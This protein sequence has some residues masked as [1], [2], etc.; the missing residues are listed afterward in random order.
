MPA[1]WLALI[2]AGQ[3]LLAHLSFGVFTAFED[4]GLYLFM[5]HRM[6]DHLLHGT[7]LR[8]YPGAF[9]SGAPGIYPVLA[10]LADDAGGLSAARSLSLIFVMVATVGVYGLTRT[11]FDR[12]AGLL[13]AATFATCGSVIYQSQWAT[14]D[15]MTMML[16]VLGAWLAL[17]GT[18]RNG[19]LWAAG[20]GG[21]L[22]LAALTKY[23]GF[24]YLP[25]V[26]A[27]TVTEGWVTWRWHIVRRALFLLASA[28]GVLYF[29]LMLW[30]RDLLHGIVQ[31]TANRTIN[32]PTARGV[33]VHDVTVWAGPWLA[34]A[35]AGGLLLVYTDRRRAG[36]AVVLLAASV[37]GVVQQIRIGEL[38]SLGKHLAFGLVF[39]APLG[40]YLLS[41]VWRTRWRLGVPTAAAVL[42]AL[43]IL[44]L[45]YADYFRTGYA[46][47]VPLQSV[48][49]AALRDNPG[50]PILGEQPSPVRYELASV[51]S[52]EQWNDTYQ[53]SFAGL[54]GAAAYRE[55]IRDHYFGVIYLSFTT[56]NAQIII[57]NL[58]T[59][60]GS[61][62]Y[63]NLVGQAP[64]VIRG[65][66]VGNWL[67]WAPQTR[68]LT[69]FPGDG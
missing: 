5:G 68:H 39:A 50:R 24:V 67:V 17:S 1:P 7:F 40:G 56:A 59:A 60:Q 15:S 12:L 35:L 18:H 58:G 48:L 4:E 22:A 53:F 65:H 44:G 13:A 10:A 63:Y 41:R 29:V 25:F 33:L 32:Q 19:L 20:V 34:L 54:S 3:A 38:T 61:G 57:S 14:Y 51:T 8:E 36:T 69:P 66:H 52:P 55:A 16:I 30:G 64:R 2:C 49:R 43:S 47:D 46:S 11:L 31:T 27:L 9:F 26:A 21:V 62:H 42:A 28:A 23:A 37:V 6:I 45:H